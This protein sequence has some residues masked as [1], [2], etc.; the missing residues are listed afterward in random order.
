M[1]ERYVIKIT[2]DGTVEAVELNGRALTRVNL[3]ELCKRRKV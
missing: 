3:P 2:T 1:A